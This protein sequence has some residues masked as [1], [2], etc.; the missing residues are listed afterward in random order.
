MTPLRASRV[1]VMAESAE[2]IK[3]LEPGWQEALTGQE[4]VFA[5]LRTELL[6]R[7][8]NGEHILPAPDAVLRAFR[9]PFADVR[10]LILGQDP[11]PTPSHPIGLSFAVAPDVRPIPRSL[12]NIYREL[13]DDLGIAPPQHG[14]LTAWTGQGVLLLN[15]V[16]TVRAGDSGSHRGLGWEQI[17]EAA[18]RALVARGT[19]L[20]S[21][22]WG[23]DARKLQPI[24]DQGEHTAVLTSPH[25]SPL[26]AHRGFF[27][28]APFSAANEALQRL[29]STPISWELDG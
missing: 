3:P 19:P 10:V 24:L 13:Q 28:S 25:P 6:T 21:I 27:G 12:A 14:D 15:R 4:P 8:N 18:L 20:V 2:L 26:S 9:Q 1:E 16:L 7:R 29:G 23:A 22:L 17:T 5:Q 11:Y